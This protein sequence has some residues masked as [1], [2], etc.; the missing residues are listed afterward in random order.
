[1]S[2][3]LYIHVPFCR[4]RCHF[5]AFYLQLYH[6]APAAA[7]VESLI[8]EINLHA[9]RHT[10]SGR[11]LATAYFG[12]GTPTT[13]DAGD[14]CRILS[15]ARSSFG[16][17]DDAELCLEAH[18]DTVTEKALEQFVAA[19]FNR[20]SVGVQSA[21]GDELIAVGRETSVSGTTAVTLARQAGFE[22]INVD[23]IYG[24]PGQTLESWRR[25]VKEVMSV[26]PTHVSCYALTIEEHTRLHVETARQDRPRP[27]PELVDAMCEEAAAV[28]SQHGYAQYEISN[29]SRLGYAC[30]HNLLYW[31]DGEYLGL[32]PSAQSYV[33]G[34]RFGNIASL[35]RYSCLLRDG[36]LPI[37]EHEVLTPEQR[38][39]EAIVFGLRRIEGVELR[40]IEELNGLHGTQPPFN[41][42]HVALNRFL[43]L[44]Y[45]EKD[46]GRLRLSGAGR[47]FADSVAAALL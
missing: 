13:L 44:G 40:A 29:F 6:E 17:E 15:V 31:T 14:L 12:G 43:G 3:G 8:R 47:R 45:L 2:V 23:L 35:D 18:P 37:D 33:D 4:S 32:G 26:Q 34:I 42:W 41:E 7:Y 19:G 9:D 46:A 25:T 1:M 28:L 11:R 22:N 38:R 10:L 36:R 30:R 27:E 21:V 39:R 24:L 16:F 20:I 5:C